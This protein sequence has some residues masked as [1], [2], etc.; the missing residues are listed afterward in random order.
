VVVVAAVL[1]TRLAWNI[2]CT[3]C[4]ALSR[5]RP[6][7]KNR[8]FSLSA[9]N[10]GS[11]KKCP[12]FFFLARAS[13]PSSVF[14]RGRDVANMGESGICYPGGCIACVRGVIGSLPA[15]R[16]HRPRQLPRPKNV[17]APH[18]KLPWTMQITLQ[19]A[20]AEAGQSEHC[21]GGGQSVHCGGGGG[22]SVH[23]GAGGQLGHWAL[24]DK[25]LCIYLL[26][27]AGALAPRD[28]DFWARGWQTAYWTVL[29]YCLLPA[30][31]DLS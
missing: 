20:E 17:H 14:G 31:T 25:D 4:Q 30:F 7:K 3:P 13:W 2:V 8:T 5:R 24:R 29:S 10:Q 22:Q 26:L 6:K 18:A 15:C 19:A 9:T 21:G 12:V 16:S 1:V 23:C 11:R 28:K 27:D